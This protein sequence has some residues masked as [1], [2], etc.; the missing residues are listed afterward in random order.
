MNVLF[1]SNNGGF[2][3]KLYEVYNVGTGGTYAVSTGSKFCSTKETGATRQ[4]IVD[5]AISMVGKIPYYY[6]EG[7]SDGYGALGHA[8]SKEFNENHFNENTKGS[9]DHK[10][11]NKYGLD[12][13]GFVDFVYWNVLD[14]NLGNGNTGTL[15]SLSTE[16]THG[17]LQPG[18]LGFLNNDSSG[19]R[20][21]VGIYIGNDEWVELN[22]SG[23]TKVHILISKF[24]IVLIF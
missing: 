9:V 24:I 16:I 19:P 17:E 23:V 13:S 6:Y 1:N 22:P 10:G 21:H 20:Q 18:D 4:Q 11:R 5:F 7:Q 3:N 14:N 8:I 2:D 15:K 12:C